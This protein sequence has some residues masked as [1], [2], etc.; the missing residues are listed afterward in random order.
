MERRRSF[1]A[2]LKAQAFKMLS[3]G[4]LYAKEQEAAKKKE[5]EAEEAP[6]WEP[7]EPPTL[8]PDWEAVRDEETG[9]EVWRRKAVEEDAVPPLSA[10]PPACP[11]D[12]EVQDQIE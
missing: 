8:P 11:V 7:S 4:G 1:A 5:G 3:T 10:A 2:E 9:S 12:E 6:E